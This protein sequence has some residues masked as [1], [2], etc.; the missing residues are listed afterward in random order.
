MAAT[1][2]KQHKALVR[3]SFNKIAQAHEVVARL[4]YEKL[5]E[6]SPEVRE[7]FKGDIT[8]QRV[9]LMQMLAIMVTSID[10]LGFLQTAA[11][12]LGKRHV[13]YGVAADHFDIVG[14]A[15]VYALK[16]ACPDVMTDQVSA[17]WVALY[18][19]IAETAITTNYTKPEK[20]E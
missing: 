13:G 17:A 2:T 7:L 1:L 20:T 9:K 6:I 19:F 10:D 14:K 11:A 5:F 15:L 16:E 3:R 4:F 8:D 18:T 12:D